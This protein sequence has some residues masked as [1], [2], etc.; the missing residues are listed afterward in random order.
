METES[1]INEFSVYIFM[2]CK[3]AKSKFEM[4]HN[5]FNNYMLAEITQTTAELGSDIVEKKSEKAFLVKL[6]DKNL[7]ALRIR[8]T[9]KNPITSKDAQ[10]LASRSNFEINNSNTIERINKKKKQW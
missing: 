5:G 7:L 1:P 2:D 8:Y 9:L 4:H 10:T 6:R 3:K